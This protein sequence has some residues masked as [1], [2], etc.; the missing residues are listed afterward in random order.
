MES[1]YNCFSRAIPASALNGD[2][3]DDNEEDD[4]GEPRDDERSGTRY[5]VCPFQHRFDSSDTTPFQYSWFHII[6]VLG[7]MYVAM[8]LTDWYE[9]IPRISVYALI[10]CTSYSGT[11]SKRARHRLRP[12]VRIST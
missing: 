1:L 11:L 4:Y 9:D 12:M 7:A 10:I 5:N 6:F 3:D 2:D 8:L